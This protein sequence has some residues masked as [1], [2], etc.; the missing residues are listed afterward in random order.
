MEKPK[1]SIEF[2]E[3]YTTRGYLIIGEEKLRLNTINNEFIITEDKKCILEIRYDLT[4]I[5]CK[6]GYRNT[7][8]PLR[9]VINGEELKKK[10]IKTYS[11]IKDFKNNSNSYAL[12]YPPEEEEKSGLIIKNAFTFRKMV[13]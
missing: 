6:K 8:N 5:L 7:S 2:L 11:I 4:K 9:L 12:T 13:K 10:F 1:C 3:S